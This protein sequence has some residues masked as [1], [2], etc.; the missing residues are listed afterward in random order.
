MFD[1][2]SHLLNLLRVADAATDETIRVDFAV[3]NNSGAMLHCD[4]AAVDSASCCCWAHFLH[5]VCQ[6]SPTDA[7]ID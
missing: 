1:M 2:P 5:C 6:R 4:S 7:G 3:S